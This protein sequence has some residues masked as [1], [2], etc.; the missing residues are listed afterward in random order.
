MSRILVVE[1]KSSLRQMLRTTLEGAGH[2]LGL[3]S[4]QVALLQQAVTSFLES[5]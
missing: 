5:L 1:D 4:W 2:D 3:S